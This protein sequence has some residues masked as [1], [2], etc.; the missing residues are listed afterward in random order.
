MEFVIAVFVGVWI[1]AAGILA[2]WRIS[3]DFPVDLKTGVVS[4]DL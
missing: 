3:K 2:Y 1:S 4:S